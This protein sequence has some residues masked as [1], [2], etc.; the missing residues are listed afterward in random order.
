MFN[1]VNIVVVAVVINEG[2]ILQ[3]KIDSS[4]KGTNHSL[5]MTYENISSS[6]IVSSAGNK[7]ISS[8]SKLPP[9]M[10]SSNR[11]LYSKDCC[12]SEPNLMDEA[13]ASNQNTTNS[14]LLNHEPFSTGTGCLE[15]FYDAYIIKPKTGGDYNGSRYTTDTGGVAWT[16]GGL[17]RGVSDTADGYPGRPISR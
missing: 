17:S 6:V 7:T 9:Q 3:S 13:Y 11:E 15:S 2:D 4:L 14:S 1:N 16:S 12:S 10:Q 8:I 5:D